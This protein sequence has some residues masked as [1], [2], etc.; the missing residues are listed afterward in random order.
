MKISILVLL[1]G[2]TFSASSFASGNHGHGH[3]H[4]HGSGHSHG[5]PKISQERSGEVGR[6]QVQRL[7]KDGK[8]DKSWL[9]STFDK[10][11]KKTFGNKSE[12]LITFKN[13][14]GPKGKLLYIFLKESGEFV[15]A[16]FTGK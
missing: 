14:K 7:V 10:S 8:I 11:I 16:N 12:W 9:K 2:L 5:E 13:D 4:S 3:G 1:M 6:S 15:A